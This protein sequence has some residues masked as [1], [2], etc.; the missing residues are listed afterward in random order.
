MKVM[1]MVKASEATESGRMP[2]ADELRAMGEGRAAGRLIAGR[3]CV[4]LTGGA[5][6]A[7]RA[8]AMTRCTG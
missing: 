6:T 3:C 5:D 2:S 8:G 1:V 7:M 4:R